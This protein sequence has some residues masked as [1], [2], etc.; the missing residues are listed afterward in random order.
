VSVRGGHGQHR[1]RAELAHL[2]AYELHAEEHRSTERRIGLL[3]A[4][5]GARCRPFVEIDL[6]LREH[7]EEMRHVRT[8]RRPRIDRAS[9]LFSC[10][11]KRRRSYQRGSSIFGLLG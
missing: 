2:H 7:V 1:P 6:G 5:G 3:G 8:R 10:A 9:S 11:A 4:L